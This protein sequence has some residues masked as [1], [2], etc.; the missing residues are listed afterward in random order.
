MKLTDT[1]ANNNTT[2]YGYASSG[3]TADP[4]WRIRSITDPLNKEVW[5]TPTATSMNGS[6]EFN[7]SN[8]IQNL[9][10]AF[11]GYGRLINAQRQQSPSAS[12]YDTVSTTYNFAGVN[13]AMYQSVACSTTADS[14]CSAYT[15]ITN[16]YDM[17][18]HLLTSVDGGGGTMTNTYTQNDVLSVVSPAPANEN[19]K[20]VQN[21][22][23]GLSRLTSS[24]AISSTVT[25]YVSCGQTTNTSATGVLTTTSY[26]SSNGSQTVSSTRGSQTRSKTADG[27]GRTTQVV[28]PEASYNPW[29]Y[30][31]DSYSSCPTGYKGASGQLTAIK[32]PNGNLVCYAY[33]SLNRVTGVNANGTTCRHF[34]YDNSTGYSGSLPSGVTTPA[35]PYGR[36]VEA[37]TDACSSGTLITDEWFSYDKDGNATDMWEK[38]PNSTEYYHSTAT[39]N[40]NHS[41]ATVKLATPSEYTMTYGIDGEGRWNTLEHGSTSIVN[42]TTYNAA[43]QPTV[44]GIGAGTDNDAY[45]YDPN[46]GRITNWEFTVGSEYES[47]APRT[48]TQTAHALG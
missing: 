34:Y 2:T 40:G 12:N 4:W 43:S 30:Y 9:T 8:S 13:P 41:I 36:V 1:D 44:I 31:Y 28:T 42:A 35:N 7:S 47:G 6:F 45:T 46:T 23:D 17:L 24:C 37:A 14:S 19:N 22:Y 10:A 33:D 39:F 25:G 20:Q 3:G 15:G 21:Q 26:A 48:G 29:N 38:T 18:G 27:L 5:I 32:D 16:T 11:D